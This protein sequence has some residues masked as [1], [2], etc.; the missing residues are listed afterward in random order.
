MEPAW[1]GICLG[2]LASQHAAGRLESR[3]HLL[4]QAGVVSLGAEQLPGLDLGT[5]T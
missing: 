1:A 2:K 5:L 4:E 3:M